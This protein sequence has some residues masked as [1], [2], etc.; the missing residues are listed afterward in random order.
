M[1]AIYDKF[2]GQYKASK[3]LTFREYIEWYTYNKLLGNISQKSV[4]DLACGEGF[5]SRRIKRKDAKLVVGV[6]ISG[7]MIKLA[8]QQEKRQPLGIEYFVSD[9]MQLGKMGSFDLV[10]ASYL[11]NYAQTQEQLLKMCQTISANLKPGGRFISINNNPNQPPES[12]PI[13]EKYGFTKSIAGPLKEGDAITYEFFRSGQK[14]RFDNY[15]LSVQ[16]HERVAKRAGLGQIRWRKME[17]SPDGIRI[18][19]QQFWQDFIDYAPIIG[20]ECKR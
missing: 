4:L 6:D 19:G 3:T 2:A 9:V 11:L 16:T 5:Y 14:F 15:Y 10:V 13:C 18:Y 20:M 1:A 12:F 8:K 17:V 7:E